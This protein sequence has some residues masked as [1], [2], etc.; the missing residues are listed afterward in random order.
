VNVA[1]VGEGERERKAKFWSVK[2]KERDRL[3]DLHVGEAVTLK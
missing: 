1:R 2:L 3:E